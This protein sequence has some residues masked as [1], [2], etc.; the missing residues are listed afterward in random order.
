MHS[1]LL[2]VATRVHLPGWVSGA[3]S[4]RR[5]EMT[6]ESLDSGSQGHRRLAKPAPHALHTCTRFPFRLS[7]AEFT[8]SA[9]MQ[10]WL[11]CLL[12]FLCKMTYRPVNAHSRHN[13]DT[14]LSPA[15]TSRSQASGLTV[16]QHCSNLHTTP[17]LR[18]RAA[19]AC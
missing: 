8:P 6:S 9:L 12:R 18:D 15:I 3:C 11:P 4:S 13:L 10:R 17:A 2:Q 5:L 7:L 14:S 1:A 16:P 19:H